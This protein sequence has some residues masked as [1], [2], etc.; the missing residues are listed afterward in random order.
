MNAYSRAGKRTSAITRKFRR[1]LLPV[2]HVEG[3][4]EREETEER[5]RE[6]RKERKKTETAMRVQQN[7]R[8][9]V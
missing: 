6:E 7:K 9:L 5:E 3:R 8:T 4:R 2:K 1:N